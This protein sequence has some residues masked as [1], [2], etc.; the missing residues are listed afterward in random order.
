[1]EGCRK[2]YIGSNEIPN[3]KGFTMNRFVRIA[4]A[5]AVAGTIVTV[6]GVAIA[7]KLE[8]DFDRELYDAYKHIDAMR[9]EQMRRNRETLDDL[10]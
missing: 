4:A 6:A 1:M 3:K 9:A 7:R 8:E 10:N 2:G 5:T